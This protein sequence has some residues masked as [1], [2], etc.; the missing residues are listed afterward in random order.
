MASRKISA[1]IFEFIV[2]HIRNRHAEKSTLLYNTVAKA[3]KIVKNNNIYRRRVKER[4]GDHTVVFLRGLSSGSSLYIHYTRPLDDECIDFT[5]GPSVPPTPRSLLRVYSGS[6]IVGHCE[7]SPF[8]CKL[9][10]KT[11]NRVPQ[12]KMF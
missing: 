12:E 3:T 9:R 7:L 5:A 6:K 4:K 11:G 1:H 2:R 8:F 10:A